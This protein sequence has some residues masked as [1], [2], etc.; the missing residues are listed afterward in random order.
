M[1]P[2]IADALLRYIDRKHALYR[3]SRID[4]RYVNEYKAYRNVLCRLLTAAKRQYFT[5]KFDNCRGNVRAIWQ[6]I[7]QIMKPNSQYKSFPTLRI[8]GKIVSN[9]SN[10]VHC[11]NTY[12]S[13]IGEELDRQLPANNVD[14]ISY[15]FRQVN[16]FVFLPTDPQE[17]I[18]I[19]SSCKSAS[20]SINTVPNFIIKKITH[21]IAPII[22]KLTNKSVS[23]GVFPDAL[24]VARVVPLLK[25]GKREDMSNY[26]PIST[27]PI[28]SKV[29]EKAMNSRL[30]TFLTKYNI[31]NVEQFGFQKNKSTSDAALQLVN[32]TYSALN[33][34][35]SLITVM[36]DFS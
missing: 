27:L 3:L 32:Y 13:S 19:V 35:N 5:K 7:N 36:F 21:I 6:N 34:R 10:V 26:R 14:P 15:L 28:L 33:N 20:G 24:K 12:F 23:R 30:Y 9:V 2:L 29:F 1:S 22:A 16:S 31:L 18:S 4:I 8:D 11:F 25:A 17:I